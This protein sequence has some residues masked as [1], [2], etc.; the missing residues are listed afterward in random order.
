VAKL[1]PYSTANERT[2]LGLR[3]QAESDEAFQV[4]DHAEM[5]EQ[6]TAPYPG[7]EATKWQILDLAH[8][9]YHAA[10]LL[11]QRAQKEAPLSYAP[12]RFCCIHA[13]EL[14]LNVFLRH[15]GADPEDIRKRKHNL[16][17]PAFV[18]KLKLR[19]NTAEHLATMTARR[20]YLISRYA[21]ERTGDHT[22][23][24]RLSAT[25]KEVMMKVGTHLNV[26]VGPGRTG[27]HSA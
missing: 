11:F 27:P 1:T 10:L 5:T 16:A 6:R 12:A 18:E 20:E 2:S 24:N 4:Q 7:S 19:R 25:L 3:M 9:Y 17:D 22:E 8:E 21:P 26:P 15:E 13:I 14:Y 23:L